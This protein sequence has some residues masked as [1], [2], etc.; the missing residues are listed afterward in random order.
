M[1]ASD[2]AKR[3]KYSEAWFTFMKLRDDLAPKAQSLQV[4]V[5]DT[6]MRESLLVGTKVLVLRT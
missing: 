4:G 6:G 2:G 1:I 3:G 5:M